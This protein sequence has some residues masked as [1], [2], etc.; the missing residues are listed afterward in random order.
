[1]AHPPVE[2][3]PG[4]VRQGSGKP[5]DEQQLTTI[6]QDMAA[7]RYTESSSFYL[8]ACAA[9]GMSL[10]EVV[11]QTRGMVDVGSRLTWTGRS[12]PTNTA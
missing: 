10:D 12:W 7:G 8:T 4:A 3:A 9:V 1:M 2:W 11:W 5:F 6:L